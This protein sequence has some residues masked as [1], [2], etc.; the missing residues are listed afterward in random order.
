LVWTIL[1]DPVIPE[2]KITTTAQTCC[3]QERGM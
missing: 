3:A 1:L 2:H